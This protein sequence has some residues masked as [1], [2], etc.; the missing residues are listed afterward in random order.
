MHNDLTTLTNTDLD[1]L[2]Q[3]VVEKSNS[4]IGRPMSESDNQSWIHLAYVE[5]KLRK[6]LN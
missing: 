5:S 1:L 6:M 3:V 4:F 2:I